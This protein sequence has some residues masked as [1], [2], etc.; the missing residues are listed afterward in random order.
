MD[1]LFHHF[2]RSSTST[3]PS[4]SQQQQQQQVGPLVTTTANSIPWIPAFGG[5]GSGSS[6]TTTSTISS[7]STSTSSSI[8]VS[9]PWT[10]YTVQSGDT[11]YGIGVNYGVPWQKIASVNNI[12]SPYYI[13][14]G[15]QLSIPLSSS[16]IIAV[17]N[18]SYNVYD[19]IILQNAEANG[20]DPMLIKS[21]MMLESNFN[22]D[23]ASP[24]DPCGVV[25]QNGV[26]VGHS[27]G[28]M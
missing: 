16:D 24:D 28:L 12:Q 25:Y 13:Y 19:S 7:T 9:G 23:A 22:P 3:S 1:N 17:P 2:A 4:S 5:V 26:D 21:E 20:I 27:Y 6:S 10:T 18:Q 14:V 11:L 15:E 8:S